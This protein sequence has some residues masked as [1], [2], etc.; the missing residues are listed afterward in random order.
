MQN[1]TKTK[2]SHT[3]SAHWQNRDVSAV[4]TTIY[5]RHALNRAANTRETKRVAAVGVPV[6]TVRAGGST[7][8]CMAPA[9][10]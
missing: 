3:N 4:G 10:N 8:T 5:H 6:G 9:G 2:G 7:G 1:Q